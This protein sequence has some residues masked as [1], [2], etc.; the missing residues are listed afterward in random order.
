MRGGVPKVSLSKRFRDKIKYVLGGEDY[1]AAIRIQLGV[2]RLTDGKIPWT[3]LEI[4]ARYWN[5][6]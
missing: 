1:I 5:L 4:M 6:K 3:G 2:L